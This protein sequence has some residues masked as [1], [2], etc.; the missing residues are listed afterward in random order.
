LAA[1]HEE[2]L[3][4][5]CSCSPVKSSVASSSTY[6][7]CHYDEKKATD[8]NDLKCN[9]LSSH[10]SWHDHFIFI[11]FI[12]AQII[13]KIYPKTDKVL[14]N[15]LVGKVMA[16]FFALFVPMVI[17][18]KFISRLIYGASVT[19]AIISQ[20]VAMMMP[21]FMIG[22]GMLVLRAETASFMNL[23]IRSLVMSLLISGIMLAVGIRIYLNP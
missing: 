19:P 20:T 17:A 2:G 7:I 4:D 13:M 23:V 3:N 11:L 14:P 9:A 8:N 18:M 10:G 16:C 15:I 22:M 21:V 6:P 12:D 5:F 1:V